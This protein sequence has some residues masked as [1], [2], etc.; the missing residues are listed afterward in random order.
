MERPGERRAGRVRCGQE[1]RSDAIPFLQHVGGW[2]PDPL[3]FGPLLLCI[4]PYCIVFAGLP[5]AGKTTIARVVARRLGA[6]YLRVDTIEQA[7]RSGGTLPAGVVAE[8]YTI[9]Y[10]VAAD[11]LALGHSVIADLVNPLGITRDAWQSVATRAGARLVDIEVICSERVEHQR[12]VEAR[13]SDIPGLP[14]PTWDAVRTRVYHRWDRPRIVIDTAG[15][16]AEACVA[17]LLA[18]LPPR[19]AA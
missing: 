2:W 7:L 16:D 5:G 19:D 3:A 8:G 10:G 4:V 1:A 18:R 13:V 11:N 12:R 9:A 17:D 15:R 14:L 6:T